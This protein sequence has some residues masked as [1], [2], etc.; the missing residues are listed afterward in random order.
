VA[1]GMHDYSTTRR[2][3]TGAVD[4]PFAHLLVDYHLQNRSNNV[5]WG[6]SGTFRWGSG[7]SAMQRQ[8]RWRGAP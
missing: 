4:A 5:R 7:Y 2:D 1:N 6:L 3:A 8:R